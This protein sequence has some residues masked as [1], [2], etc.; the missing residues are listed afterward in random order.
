MAQGKLRYQV[1]GMSL[2]GKSRDNCDGKKRPTCLPS[3]KLHEQLIKGF[4]T[5][6]KFIPMHEIEEPDQETVNHST[7]SFWEHWF[8]AQ[9]PARAPRRSLDEHSVWEKA[10]SFGILAAEKVKC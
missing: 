1:E 2:F 7:G 9:S 4:N 8:R 6:A 10:I 3:K 5:M